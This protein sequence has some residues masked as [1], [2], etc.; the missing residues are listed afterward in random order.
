MTDSIETIAFD[1]G[2]EAYGELTWGQNAIWN[3]LTWLAPGQEASLNQT[4]VRELP[5]GRDT[6]GVLAAIRRLVERHDSLRTLVV[7]E[8]GIPKQRRAGVGQITVVCRDSVGGEI[9]G[10]AAVLADELARRPFDLAEDLP[11]RVGLVYRDGVPVRV[12]LAV[13]HLAVDASSLRILDADFEKLLAGNVLG[14]RSQQPLER[15]A[16]EA[17][18]VMQQRQRQSLAYWERSTRVISATWLEDLRHGG[19]PQPTWGELRSPGLAAAV[20]KLAEEHATTTATVLQALIGLTLAIEHH[21]KDVALRCIVATRFTRETAELVGAFNLNALFRLDLAD[22]PATAFFGRAK[23]A[24]LMALAHCECHQDLLN[25]LVERTAGER[26]I[27]ADG[28]C[29]YN[30]VRPDPATTTALDAAPTSELFARSVITE[31]VRDD[32]QRGSKFF[33]YVSA[34]D[35]EAELTLCSDRRFVAADRF[36]RDLDWVAMT[37]WTTGD[38]PELVRQAYLKAVEDRPAG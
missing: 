30:D 2:D 36:L 7:S 4:A 17:G 37:M 9:A 23:R 14:P 28:Y 18:P 1:Y 5:A 25:D 38:G 10:A 13:S 6:D 21:E 19:G 31:P 15:A 32:D 33:V 24:A 3:V 16:Q 11:L 8:A 22:E 26:G 20:Q 35:D 34:L 27:T 29:F 12:C